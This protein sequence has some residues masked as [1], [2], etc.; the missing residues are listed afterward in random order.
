MFEIVFWSMVAAIVVIG[1]IWAVVAGHDIE[2]FE[3]H[4]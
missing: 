3:E 1:I 2:D 4:R